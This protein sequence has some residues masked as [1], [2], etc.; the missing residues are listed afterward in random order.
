[1]H[2]FWV[3]SRYRLSGRFWRILL[4]KSACDRR[5]RSAISLGATRFDPDADTLYATLTLRNTQSLSGWRSG[6]QRREPSQVLSNGGQ[7]KFVLNAS[8]TTQSKPAEFQD[9][10]QVCEPHLDLLT[11]TARLLE[12]FGV[13]KR[14]GNV[15]G[16]FMDVARDL[17]RWIF[18]TALRFERAY[19]AVEFACTIQK[20]LTLMYGAARP[21]P[22]SARAMVDIVGRIISK[23]AAREG[24]VVPLRFVEPGI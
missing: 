23:V 2:P 17:A 6:N 11:L 12:G 19:I 5:C 24:A 7:N 22:L 1:M 4:Q 3:K 10:L 21:E 20:C 13:R 15:S 8:W 16:V 14:P 9:A 18:R